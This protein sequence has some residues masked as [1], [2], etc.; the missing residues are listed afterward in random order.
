MPI[1]GSGGAIISS[2]TLA[3][4]R[5]MFGA[6]ARNRKGGASGAVVALVRQVLAVDALPKR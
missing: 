5:L 3:W 6:P 2:G 1:Q 4:Q